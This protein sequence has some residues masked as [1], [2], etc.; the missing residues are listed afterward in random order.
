MSPL[1]SVPRLE[2]NS[3]VLENTTQSATYLLSGVPVPVRMEQVEWRIISFRESFFAGSLDDNAVASVMED[4][5]I[6][7]FSSKDN[8]QSV[9]T[10][11]EVDRN[12]SLPN[13]PLSSPNYL[14]TG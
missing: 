7:D 8:G 14:Q 3:P 4:S 11:M 12:E 2:Q 5:G 1:S 10:C 9:L 6:H 13:E